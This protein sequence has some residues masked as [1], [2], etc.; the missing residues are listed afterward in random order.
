VIEIAHYCLFLLIVGISF[1]P[2]KWSSRISLLIGSGLGFSFIG[3][4]FS[5]ILVSSHCTTTQ[6]FPYKIAAFWSNYEG[7][8]LVWVILLLAFLSCSPWKGKQYGM[9]LILVFLLFLGLISNPLLKHSIPL[10]E[11]NPLNL[12]LQ[13]PILLIHPPCVFL[14]YVSLT[15]PLLGSLVYLKTGVVI[16]QWFQFGNLLALFFL[17]LGLGL[18]SWWAYQELGWGGYWFWDPVE[19]CSLI[20]WILTLLIFH[21]LKVVPEKIFFIS[22]LSILCFLSS[23]LATLFVR[24]GNS[25]HGFT[26]QDGRGIWLALFLSVGIVYLVVLFFKNQQYVPLFSPN[27][28][29]LSTE[30]LVFWVIGIVF[31]LIGVLLFGLLAPGLDFKNSIFPIGI[32]LL[33]FL[34]VFYPFSYVLY[35]SGVFFILFCCFSCLPKFVLFFIS[36]LVFFLRQ[37]HLGHLGFVL[38]VVATQLNTLFKQNFVGLSEGGDSIVVTSKWKLHFV[39]FLQWDK[40]FEGVFLIGDEMNHYF[41]FLLPTRFFSNKTVLSK[42]DLVSNG[43]LDITEIMGEGDIDNGVCLFVGYEPFLP[44]LWISI[45]LVVVSIFVHY[46][47][48]KY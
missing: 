12:I 40:F 2:L 36:L 3:N 38:F 31:I 9:L 11:G 16:F 18:G 4:D 8:F 35:C 29:S 22:G 46:S 44:F 33:V 34:F 14:G 45:F 7:S 27:F 28:C 13:D 10:L 25:I 47:T 6:L 39:Q 24:S 21:L 43:F 32:V 42:T 48:K 37:F 19:T 20:P 1:F 23:L 41:G 15:L 5:S 17:T 30:K 26:N